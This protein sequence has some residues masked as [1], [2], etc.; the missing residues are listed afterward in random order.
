MVRIVCTRGSATMQP[1]TLVV[2]ED[3]PTMYPQAT[4]PA[5]DMIGPCLVAMPAPWHPG[6]LGRQS[7]PAERSATKHPYP[8]LRFPWGIKWL[9]YAPNMLSTQTARS[10]AHDIGQRIK[11]GDLYSWIGG[12][13]NS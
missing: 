11:H 8:D 3:C 10:V 1:I 4:R 7:W 6:R 2:L 5:L 9:G 13:Q 12:K